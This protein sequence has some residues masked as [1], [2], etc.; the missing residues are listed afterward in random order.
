MGARYYSPGIGRFI[1][2]DPSGF[3]AGTNLYAFCG[4]DP[5]NH[6]DPNGC[7]GK[8]A[9]LPYERQIDV[10]RDV[11]DAQDSFS[12]A[13]LLFCPTL[14]FVPN[15]AAMAVN[16][17][18]AW[19]D[20]GFAAGNTK[21][22]AQQVFL[23]G[24]NAIG[25]TVGVETMFA[26][27]ISAGI[28]AI[29]EEGIIAGL[30]PGGCFVAGTP[31]QA[32][33]KGKDGKYHAMVKPIEKVRKGDLVLA[34]D[35]KTGRTQL[36][37]VL[38]TTVRQVAKVLA[39]SLAD[40][41][42]R[43][44]VE[45]ITASRE[46]PFYVRGKGFVPAGGL[47]VGNAIVTRAGPALIVKSIKWNR[48]PEGYKVYNFVVEDDHSYFV[49]RASGGVWVHNPVWCSPDPHVA[50]IANAI[51]AEYPGHVV[52][53]NEIIQDSSGLTITDIDIET[54][55]AIIQ[56]KSGTGGGLGRQITSSMRPE[57]NPTGKPVIGYAPRMSRHVI[58]EVDG[59][60]GIA[61]GDLRTLLDILAP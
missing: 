32:A 57:V 45:T 11:A 40:A 23:A 55:N 60:G 14:A 19:A 13:A 35:Q 17:Y 42:T 18:D 16:L 47:A 56:V 7:R 4:C 46:H 44:V 48:R 50:N 43:K 3:A 39:I 51:E 20:W 29:S 54:Q 5:I 6:F 22:S 26:A 1:S 25:Q 2:R 27:P 52:R 59:R 61:T 8:Y 24:A 30:G 49:G 31:V 28:E 10:M 15:G 12:G 41:K 58:R 38:R 34:R 9:G 33:V 53:V 37:P 36:R 21:A